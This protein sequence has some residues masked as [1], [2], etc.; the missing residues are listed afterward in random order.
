MTQNKEELQESIPE[1]ERAAA[2]AKAKKKKKKKI[3]RVL[4]YLLLVLIGL[5][6]I[7]V[8]LYPM[9][10]NLYSD[11]MQSKIHTA[12]ERK[13]ENVDNSA[14]EA[15]LDLAKQY[16]RELDRGM[17]YEENRLSMNTSVYESRL[18]ATGT[19]IMG[20]VEVPLIDVN[21]P[22]YHGTNLSGL[23][24]G[25]VHLLGT[26]LPVGGESTH[27]ALSAHTG[28]SSNKLFTDLEAVKV[29][30]VFYI[31][32][33]KQTLAYKVVRVD[34]VEPYDTS[35]LEI[36][37]G[38]D[39]VTLI[40]CTPYGINS[41]RLLVRGSR[42]PYQEAIEIEKEVQKERPVVE[43][44]WE[45]KYIEGIKYGLIGAGAL[46][47]IVIIISLIKKQMKRRRKQK[48]NT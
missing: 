44:Q 39:L 37:P 28:L 32:V 43:S 26:S 40:T 13:M 17:S 35:L 46:I 1:E 5:G 24:K 11:Q 18:D 47:V 14:L 42:V 45:A 19:G 41:H 4:L 3:K 27:C 8:I 20:Y 34:V 48:P 30:D 31:H 38:E 36:V 10:S 2:A 23:E 7:G 33:M 15:Q 21:L 6:C 29:G 12:Y 16:N 9:I 25:V 22:I